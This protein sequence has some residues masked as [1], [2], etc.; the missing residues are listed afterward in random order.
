M[1]RY[2]HC[3]DEYFKAKTQDFIATLCTSMSA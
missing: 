3:S 1:P 2:L